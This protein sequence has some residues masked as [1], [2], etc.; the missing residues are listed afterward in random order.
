MAANL[1]MF[2]RCRVAPG[3]HPQDPAAGDGGEGEDTAFQLAFTWCVVWTVGKVTTAQQKRRGRSF[4][5]GAHLEGG[6]ITSK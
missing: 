3:R 6:R 4:V 5:V 2:S 1:S